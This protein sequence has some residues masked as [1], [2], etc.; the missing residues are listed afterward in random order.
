[1]KF[2]IVVLSLLTLTISCES[3]I[4][5]ETPESHFI[6]KWRLSERGMLEG[7]EIEIKK[8][9]TGNLIGEITKLNED[10]YV[11]IFMEEGDKFMTKIK[12]KSNFEFVI[13]EKKIAAPL[14]ST[15]GQSTT[16][17]FKVTFDGNDKILLGNNGSEGAYVRL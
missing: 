2:L 15:Y 14:F 9:K 6:G 1:M 3:S 16:K 4:L 11:T 5:L 12:R 17:E 8:D 13:S 7:L 10:K